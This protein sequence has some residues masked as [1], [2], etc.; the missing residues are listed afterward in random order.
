[1]D[2]SW[3]DLPDRTAKPFTDGV[4]TFLDFAFK[5][6]VNDNRIY[7]PCKKCRNQFFV[8]KEVAEAHIIVHGFWSKYKKWKMHGEPSTSIESNQEKEVSYSSSA[9]MQ[10]V[11][12][13]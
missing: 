11:L 4:K 2:K 12:Q 1:M 6:V 9:M 10:C 13:I 5:N 8:V 3:I 7:Y